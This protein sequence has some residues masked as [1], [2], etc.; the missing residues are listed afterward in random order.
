MLLTALLLLL[1]AADAAAH[2]SAVVVYSV[3]TKSQ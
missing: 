3:A 2:V 1:H